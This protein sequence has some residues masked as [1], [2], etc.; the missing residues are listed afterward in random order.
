M[1]IEEGYVYH[2]KNEY[3]EFVKDEKLITNHE[4]DST[5]PNYFCIKINDEN[6]M[7]FVPMSSKVE[8]YKKLFK[9]KWKNIKNVIL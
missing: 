8:K 9:I 4:G 7:W 6:V 5:R 3:F 1:I 2:I